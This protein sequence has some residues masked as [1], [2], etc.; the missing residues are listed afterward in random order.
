M[1]LLLWRPRR[2]D[3]V[4]PGVN[5][6][7]CSGHESPSD[8]RT[9]SL[10]MRAGNMTLESLQRPSHTRHIAWALQSDVLAHS[11]TKVFVTHAGANSLHE[12]AYHAT[13]VVAVPFLG[14]QPHNAA[15]VAFLSPV[16]LPVQA[17][18]IK[19]TA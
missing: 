19:A 10:W 9:K 14:D 6:Y 3:N 2:Q 1:L 4:V 18:V 7:G 12:A 15:K 16:R 11:S 8:W 5:T 17:M 13:L